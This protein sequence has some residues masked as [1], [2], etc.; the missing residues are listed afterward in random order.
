[1]A[2][3]FGLNDIEF[4]EKLLEYGLAVVPGSAFYA[5]GFIRLSFAASF[6]ELVEATKILK[7]FFRDRRHVFNENWFTCCRNW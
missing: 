2:S 1:M 4:C 3:E 7:T 6:N 5:D